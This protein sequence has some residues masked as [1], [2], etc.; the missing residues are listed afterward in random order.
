M[1]GGG[2]EDN[3]RMVLQNFILS[4]VI[5][6]SVLRFILRNCVQFSLYISLNDRAVWNCINID[7]ST[8]C[9]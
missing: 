8:H 2:G 6:S 7:L 3:D 1:G 4:Y 5:T 9:S